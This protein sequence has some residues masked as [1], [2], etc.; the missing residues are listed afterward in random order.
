MASL[1]TQAELSR[2]TGVSPP[3]ICRAFKDGLKDAV[4]INGKYIDTEHPLVALYLQ[5]HRA[6]LALKGP[7]PFAEGRAAAKIHHSQAV[8]RAEPPGPVPS[9][10]PGGSLN[11]EN[12]LRDM[13]ALGQGKLPRDIEDLGAM[14]MREV[15]E[16]F[17][18]LPGLRD[19][20]K[21]LKDFA[22]MQVAEGTAAK[23]RGELIERKVIPAVFMPFL[24]MAT[25]RLVNEAPQALRAQIV[26]RV[27]A[28][29]D[30]LATD[31][32]NMIVHE[33]SNILTECKSSM[34][35]ALEEL[36]E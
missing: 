26:A 34:A 35:R 25:K 15:A 6:K 23:K 10:G 8:G 2:M 18:T 1:V 31:V 16:R 14:T 30:D 12:A 7:D 13:Q 33:N 11:T 4:S 36:G 3:T 28:G 29:G 19:V 32:E 22:T 21:S 20:V 9:S 27:L 17:G 5:K 24:E